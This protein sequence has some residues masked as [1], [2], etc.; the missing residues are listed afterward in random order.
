MQMT[1]GEII[2][3]FRQ[4]ANPKEQLTILAELNGSTVENIKSILGDVLWERLQKP[5]KRGP[6]PRKD[7]HITTDISKIA[8]ELRE[9]GPVE[10]I[11]VI[12]FEKES[13]K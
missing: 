9:I 13:A 5:A 10:R 11:I 8:K 12:E 7:I 6:K 2:T 4:A 3:N 1:V